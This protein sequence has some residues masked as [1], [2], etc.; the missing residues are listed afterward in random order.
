MSFSLWQGNVRLPFQDV[1]HLVAFE[2]VSTCS[3]VLNIL[4]VLKNRCEGGLSVANAIDFCIDLLESC[5]KID[6]ED[7][8]LED[9]ALDNGKINKEELNKVKLQFVVEQLSLLSKRVHQRRYS[10]K[11]LATCALWENTSPNLYRQMVEEGIISL[12]SSK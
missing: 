6:V 1:S 12:P 3:E 8:A 5:I 2:K 9:E 7:E 10:P 11:F 4:S